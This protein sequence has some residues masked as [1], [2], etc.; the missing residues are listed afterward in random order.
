MRVPACGN[1]GHPQTALTDFTGGE[2]RVLTVEQGNTIVLTVPRQVSDPTAAG[3]VT[4]F[5]GPVEATKQASGRGQP[6]TGE[7]V[8]A[9]EGFP[10]V[11]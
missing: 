9:V 5:A 2:K 7:V 1:T 6:D 8:G 11:E 10:I 4:S 3:L